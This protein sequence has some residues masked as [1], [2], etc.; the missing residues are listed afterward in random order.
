M[1]STLGFNFPK[2]GDYRKLSMIREIFAADSCFCCSDVPMPRQP[3]APISSVISGSFLLLLQ[4]D[5]H[6]SADCPRTDT[7]YRIAKHFTATEQAIC[8]VNCHPGHRVVQAFV[9][10]VAEGGSAIKA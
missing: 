7:R 10:T 4:R 8:I 5:P 9:I 3:D 1:I 6:R 2:C